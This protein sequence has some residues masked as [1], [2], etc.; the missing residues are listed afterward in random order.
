VYR[1]ALQ[2][3]RALR[4]DPQLL[5]HDDGGG[6]TMERLENENDTAQ[7]TLYPGL[8]HRTAGQRARHC[9]SASWSPITA[10]YSAIA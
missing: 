3:A 5:A 8:G 6:M 7:R 1:Q 2:L 10:S 4:G 9:G